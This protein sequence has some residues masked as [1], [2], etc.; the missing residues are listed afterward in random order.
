MCCNKRIDSCIKVSLCNTLLTKIRA[1][2]A[3]LRLYSA[4]DPIGTRG[5]KNC[6][7]LV[8][9]NFFSCFFT[10]RSNNHSQSLQ[11][12][13]S[14]HSFVRL[15]KVCILLWEKVPGHLLL[16]G[17][18]RKRKRTPI[19]ATFGVHLL[20]T[21][22]TLMPPFLAVC[23]PHKIL[24]GPGVQSERPHGRRYESELD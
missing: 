3:R 17:V 2:P 8:S 19:K 1:R 12:E 22:S 6:T 18:L 10:P 24:S 14:V 20:P 23:T 15:L 13:K 16:L 7:C 5:K 4:L 21:S 9:Y 11:K